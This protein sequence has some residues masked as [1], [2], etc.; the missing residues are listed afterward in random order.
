MQL[1]PAQQ[2]GDILTGLG[3]R[4]GELAARIGLVLTRPFVAP[5]RLDS[6]PNYIGNSGRPRAAEGPRK[7]VYGVVLQP[8]IS[9]VGSSEAQPSVEVSATERVA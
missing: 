4:V 2:G 7:N 1:S 6:N 8:V 5:L 3:G 9:G